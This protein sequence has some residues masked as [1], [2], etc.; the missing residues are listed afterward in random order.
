MMARMSRAATVRVREL[1]QAFPPAKCGDCGRCVECERRKAII[2][3][4]LKGE[5]LDAWRRAS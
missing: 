3:T 1:R 2:L 4:V 5:R